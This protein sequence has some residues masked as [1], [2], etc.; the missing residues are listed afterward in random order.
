M[1]YG[2]KVATAQSSL[3]NKGEELK[4]PRRRQGS[5]GRSQKRLHPKAQRMG[6][7]DVRLHIL[8][9]DG[10]AGLRGITE[11][12]REEAHGGNAAAVEG[13]AMF[14]RVGEHREMS[15]RGLLG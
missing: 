9:R 10:K 14:T 12:W 1:N 13:E 15:G 2:V 5:G 11:P 8:I 3:L 6:S 7:K 4:G